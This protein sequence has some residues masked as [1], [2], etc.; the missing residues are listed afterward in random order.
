MLPHQNRTAIIGYIQVCAVELS[1]SAQE[2]VNWSTEKLVSNLLLLLV[3][4]IL[5]WRLCYSILLRVPGHSL[6]GV[7][8]PD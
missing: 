1:L 4:G 8:T 3:Y 7:V 6:S 5:S 2:F